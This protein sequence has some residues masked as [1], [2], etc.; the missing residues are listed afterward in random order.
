MLLS[1]DI[2]FNLSSKKPVPVLVKAKNLKLYVP[3]KISYT[4]FI[5]KNFFGEELWL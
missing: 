3:G 4:V 1:Y 2:P 5:M